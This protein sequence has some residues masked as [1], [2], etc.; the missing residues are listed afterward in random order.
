[1]EKVRVGMIG[2]GG[3]ATG[4]HMAALRKQHR[5]AEMVAFCDSMPEKAEKAAKEF[6]AEGAKIYSDYRRLLEDK[7]ID[8]VHIC[9]PNRTHAEISVAA[10]EAGKHVMCEKP[11]AKT[12]AEA[13]KMAEAAKR[14]GMKLAIGYQNRYTPEVWTMKR[15]ADS[16]EFGEIYYAKA[17]A[18]RRRAV[19]TWGV[20]LSE[21]EQGGGPLIDIGT[22]ALDMTLWVMNN[23]K[24]KMVVG[25]V[26]KKLG[27]QTETGN[28]WGDWNP[29]EYTVEDSAFGFIQME[30]GATVSLESSWALNVADPME[31]RTTIC[32]TLGGADMLDGLRFNKVQYGYPTLTKFAVGPDGAEFYDGK[33]ETPADKEC[34]LWL[35][36]ILEDKEVIAKPE[37][38]LVVSEI[39]E[40]IYVSGKT[41]KPVYFGKE[42][43]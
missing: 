15:A 10:M 1:M 14:T 43:I 13:R 3:I 16:G 9:T 28:A 20:F 39:L 19:P 35:D 8:A 27:D 24:P 29:A 2:C 34:R 12:A 7:T 42:N 6:G 5:R 23:Y 18:L 40:A 26:Y 33:G 41:G 30:N 32:G 4:K 11:M 37:E 22:H 21:Y 25:S 38:A 36:A 17:H 31:A